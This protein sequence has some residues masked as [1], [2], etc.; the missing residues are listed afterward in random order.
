[1]IRNLLKSIYE[2]I[3]KIVTFICVAS[4]MFLVVL[5]FAS[6]VMRYVFSSPIKGAQEFSIYLL[7]WFGF[8]GIIKGHR[9]GN[10]ISISYF[11]DRL[12]ETG[13]KII[14][15]F[16]ELMVMFFSAT[17]FYQ[18]LKLYD[19]DII[20]PL[21]ATNIPSRTLAALIVIVGFMLVIQS[22]IK[23]FFMVFR[24]GELWIQQ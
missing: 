8:L 24:E 14:N 10:H 18:G 20:S 21:P 7:L 9:D 2:T 1:M 4:L 5:V 19:Y 22:L 23:M 16:S 13:Q 3:Y 17:M 15:L 12:P 11:T 6:V